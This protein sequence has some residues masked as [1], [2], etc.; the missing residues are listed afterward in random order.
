M[1]VVLASA[2]F[3]SL[4]SS[5]T[6]GLLVLALILFGF[7][8]GLLSPSLSGLLSR[9]TPAAEQGAVFGVLGAAQTLARMISYSEANL[10]LGRVSLSAPY[11]AAL[12]FDVLALL[13]AIAILPRYRQEQHAVPTDPVLE[14]EEPVLSET[15][16]S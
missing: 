10:L 9:I 6:I 2:A 14:V 5:K 1:G 15:R 4:A 8:Q 12:G 7:G 13:V 11:W 3:L 16:Q